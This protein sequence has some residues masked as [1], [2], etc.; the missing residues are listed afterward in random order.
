[1]NHA[2]RSGRFGPHTPNARGLCC[3]RAH[4]TKQ[5]PHPPQTVALAVTGCATWY[6][7]SIQWPKQKPNGANLSQRG[8]GAIQQLL[9]NSTEIHRF[10]DDLRVVKQLQR[11]VVHCQHPISLKN[12][13][14][15]SNPCIC[16]LTEITHAAV[17]T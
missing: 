4:S 3:T 15:S 11:F 17:Q 14:N 2:S 7:N 16:S 10:L 1:M 9:L 13:H 12:K 5:V 8:V 6:H